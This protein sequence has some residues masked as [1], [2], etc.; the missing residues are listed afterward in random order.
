MSA[1]ISRLGDYLLEK[2]LASECKR[3]GLASASTPL[4]F[5]HIHY[6][7]NQT[8]R[9]EE[10]AVVLLH[11]AATDKSSWVRFA[12][13]LGKPF[14]LLI[15]DLPGHGDSVVDLNLD[16]SIQAQA[17]RLK[18]W[19]AT[20]GVKRVHLIGNSMGGA[21]AV[22]LAAA[23]PHLVASLVLIDAAGFETSPSWL[24]QHM[25]QIG[26]NPMHEIRNADDYR[27]MMRIGMVNPPYIPGFMLS[28]LAR[29][30]VQRQAINQ[31]IVE[32]I[33]RDINQT[34]SLAKIHVPSLIIWGAEDKVEHVANAEFLHQQLASSKNIIMPGI[35]HVPMVE[36]PKPV[37][38]ACKDFLASLSSITNTQSNAI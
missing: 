35:G 23:M 37:A 25:T 18:E 38:A 34:T 13:H 6:L 2:A 1:L 15:P 22:H 31:K 7:T 36:V 19:F 11:G 14:P 33:A 27:T 10:D 4:S 21:I 24:Q 26:L 5:G 9:F 12:K 16:Y 3:A 28:A 8:D 29:A 20:L 32:D 30:A 17:E